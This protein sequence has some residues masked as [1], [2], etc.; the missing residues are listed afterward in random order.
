LHPAQF[1]VINARFIG[2]VRDGHLSARLGSRPVQG[3]GVM[4]ESRLASRDVLPVVAEAIAATSGND[5]PVPAQS[6]MPAI[7]AP[8]IARLLA[9]EY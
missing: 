4:T 3:V 7:A 5:R 1:I 8:R 2:Q 6:P 9:E